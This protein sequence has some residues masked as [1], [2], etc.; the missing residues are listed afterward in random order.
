MDS[1][2]PKD[3]LRIL[4]FG[5][6]VLLPMAQ[7]GKKFMK[8]NHCA[9][10]LIYM[11]SGK[12]S[13]MLTYIRA[14]HLDTIKKS[15]DRKSKAPKVLQKMSPV[16]VSSENYHENENVQVELTID[17]V[18][19]DLNKLN[20]DSVSQNLNTLPSTPLINNN[21]NMTLLPITEEL[22]V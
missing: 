18:F 4:Q 14:V 16:T 22:S 3:V 19:E 12:T 5:T 21:G 15:T 9:K 20:L 17:S 13:N 11:K 7:M 10:Q 8:C 1:M 6:I 2:F